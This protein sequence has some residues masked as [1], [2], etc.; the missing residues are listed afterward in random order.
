MKNTTPK[1]GLARKFFFSVLAATA[2]NTAKKGMTEK[3][4]KEKNKKIFDCGKFIRLSF[5]VEKDKTTQQVDFENHKSSIILPFEDKIKFSK[6]IG[7]DIEKEM[8]VK[9]KKGS[10]VKDIVYMADRPSENICLFY[11]FKDETFKKINL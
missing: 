10:P 6:M 8:L 2:E 5:I 9:N 7:L 1:R 3:A 4:I 11:T